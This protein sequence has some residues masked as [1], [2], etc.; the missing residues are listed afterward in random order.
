[1]NRRRSTARATIPCETAASSASSAPALRNVS[2]SP[3]PIAD[4]ST[5]A[6]RE[7]SGKRIDARADELLQ[8]LRD[9]QR[10]S[11]VELVRQ[12]SCDLERVE[13]IAA[14]RLVDPEQRRPREGAVEPL[15]DD[16]L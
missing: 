11:G 2:V 1:M 5:S 8:R 12:G 3:S 7:G 16:G 14:R 10:L 9:G 6:F 13:R 15:A 4:K